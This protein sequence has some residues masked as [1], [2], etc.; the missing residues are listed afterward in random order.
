M[1]HR[2]NRTDFYRSACYAP[3]H[4]DEHGVARFWDTQP[5]TP[6]HTIYLKHNG[7]LYFANHTKQE[8]RSF[9]ALALIGYTHNVC[10]CL[11]FYAY[12]LYVCGDGDPRFQQ[13]AI[14]VS[15][16]WGIYVSAAVQK[17]DRRRLRY[18]DGR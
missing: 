15:H 2:R 8:M 3:L 7:Q 5:G 18:N 13:D 14:G 10:P 11:S 17:K 9:L 6:H 4:R 1:S 16:R 12:W